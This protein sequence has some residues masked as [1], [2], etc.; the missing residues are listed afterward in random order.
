MAPINE[1]EAWLEARRKGITGTDVG[2]V[3]GVSPWGSAW[4]VY[5][6]KMG[7]SSSFEENERMMWGKRMEPLLVQ[8]Y[9]EKHNVSVEKPGLMYGK[10]DW[11]IANPD[12][13]VKNDNEMLWGVE[14]K[15]AKV[16]SSSSA[17]MWS[18][19]GEGLVVPP[20]YEYQCR[21]YMM[22][23]DLPRWDLCVLMNGNEWRE[24]VIHRSKELE[25]KMYEKCKSFWFDFV[26]NRVEPR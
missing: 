20:D 22:A 1:H 3:M 24:Y 14:I 4:S 21:W 2:K 19:Q 17:K 10:E 13:V 9:S 8:Y 26:V 12:A 16:C 7:R 25:E 18:K 6:D 11:I 5:E 23:L 15:T